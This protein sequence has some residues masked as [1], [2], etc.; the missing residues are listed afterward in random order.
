MEHIVIADTNLFFECGHL[1][2]LPWAE[3]GVDPVVVALTKPVLAEID[4]HKKGGGRT[5][6]RALDVSQRVRAMLGGRGEEIIRNAGPRVVLRLWS[7]V[8][9]DPD[10]EL[11]LDYNQNDDRIVGIVSTI[12]KDRAFASVRFLTDD[13]V[14]A[15]TAQSLGLPFILIPEPW[16]RP[17]EE[18]TEAKQIREL[19][20]DLATYRAQ[21][22][23]IALRNA[24]EAE[25]RAVRRV[26]AALGGRVV[27]RLIETLRAQHP[28]QDSFDA[29]ESEML[30]DGTEVSYEAPDPKAV[31][32][33]RTEAYPNWLTKCR[34]VLESL[35]DDRVERELPL[36]LM[37]GLANKGTRPAS[38]MRVSFEVL[39]DIRLRRA[40][41]DGGGGDDGAVTAQATPRPFPRLPLPPGA[42]G[43]E[44]RKAPRSC[45]GRTRSCRPA[46]TCGR[47][48]DRHAGVGG[49]CLRRPCGRALAVGRSWTHGGL[50]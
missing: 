38:R 16:K 11:V 49:S 36:E 46:R 41:D 25:T 24:G 18:T 28:M 50:G 21:E 34:S 47:I 2:D 8:R 35:H 14:A 37:I 1:E 3:L 15:S 30:A 31:T 19:Q 4:K 9:P 20:R 27:D 44:H 7:T 10:H 26:P 23:G 6:K 40:S 42:T 22:P 48:A 17:P 43:P 29:P 33:Y 13:S 39:G 45:T 12:A 32:K 5:R